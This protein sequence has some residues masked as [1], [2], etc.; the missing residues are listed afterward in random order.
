[1]S[2]IVITNAGFQEVINAEANGTAPVVLARVGFGRG[3]RKS[4][5]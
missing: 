5:V 1:M 2:G 4:V 3:D